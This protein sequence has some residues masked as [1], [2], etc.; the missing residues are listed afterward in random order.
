MIRKNWK[1]LFSLTVMLLLVVLAGTVAL[2]EEDKTYDS[3]ALLIEKKVV[4]IEDGEEKEI[5]PR[6]TVYTFNI[7]GNL[8]YYEPGDSNPKNHSENKNETIIG[9]GKVWVPY[10]DPN[11]STET[12][13][14][15]TVTEVLGGTHSLDFEGYKYEYKKTEVKCYK[16][17]DENVEKVPFTDGKKVT[18]VQIGNDVPHI[19]F[20]NIYEKVKDEEPTGSLTVSK[21]VTEGGSTEQLFNFVVTVEVDGKPIPDGTYGGMTFDNGTAKFELMHN[22][23]KTAEG[24][25]IGASYTVEETP[26]DGWESD[27]KDGYRGTISEEN[28]NQTVKFANTRQL[29]YTPMVKKTV[30]QFGEVIK[31]N[32]KFIFELKPKA[33]YSEDEVVM[34]KSTTAEVS[35]N[36]EP[37]S[38][39]K[40]TFKKEG[41]YTFTITEVGSEEGNGYIY[42]TSKWELTVTVEKDPEDEKVLIAVP[43][44]KKIDGN[45]ANDEA[46]EFIN[47]WECRFTPWVEKIMLDKKG[48]ELDSWQKEFTFRLEAANVRLPSETFYAEGSPE[49]MGRD[50]QL[51]FTV[52][53][54]DQTSD[55]A[56]IFLEGTEEGEYKFWLWEPEESNPQNGEVRYDDTVYELT[57]TVE[58]DYNGKLTAKLTSWQAGEVVDDRFEATGELIKYDDRDAENNG[59][60]FE[61]QYADDT[62]CTYMPVVEKVVRASD[63]SPL[64]DDSARFTFKLTYNGNSD[65]VELG[66]TTAAAS[67]GNPGKFGAITFEE[68]GT[69]EFTITE[70]ART[71]Y[72]CDKPDGVKLVVTVDKDMNVTAVYDDKKDAGAAVFTNTQ[73]EEETGEL[74]LRKVVSGGPANA[75]DKT[76]TF[77]VTG[78]GYHETVTITGSGTAR[79]EGLPVGEYTVTEDRAGAEAD[80]YTL[81]VTGEGTVE[82]TVGGEAEATIT[83]TYEEPEEPEKPEEPEEPELP[84]PNDPDSPETVTIVEDDV[85]KTY[86]KVWDPETEQFMYIPEDE[87]PLFGFETPETGDNSQRMILA[88]LCALSLSG[89]AGL[90]VT[91]RRNKKEQ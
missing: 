35:G 52:D 85:P 67:A 50:M 78:E 81:T 55:K 89:I 9:A 58:T 69:Y 40:I 3:Y 65:K 42:D 27:P 54:E 86:V 7:T 64:E 73:T 13:K 53:D 22:Q 77:T 32:K 28:S 38:L 17:G 43:S 16:E 57:V 30:T 10:N 41:T 90:I 8:I 74:I 1:K 66:E 59:I 39:G 63:G 70:D 76:F 46:A 51:E 36:G 71:G 24:L 79:L 91:K 49:K 56:V 80:G 60:R 84:D 44:Y 15:L 72:N 20:K 47:Q 4:V 18:D 6:E 19:I 45:D 37:Q 2:A 33:K 62:P 31:D 23:S 14:G 25:P 61:N 11:M 87:V 34:P 21:T 75:A 48:N 82:V 83:N 29:T 12:G 5:D 88:G 68:P 26:E